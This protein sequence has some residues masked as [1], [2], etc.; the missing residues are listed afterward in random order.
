MKHGKNNSL[1][2][3]K[4]KRQLKHNRCSKTTHK[5]QKGQIQYGG[6]RRKYKPGR[7]PGFNEI[8]IVMRENYDTPPPELR[9]LLDIRHHVLL[10]KKGDTIPIT[11]PPNT[12]IE[13]TNHWFSFGRIEYDDETYLKL[14]SLNLQRIIID[15]LKWNPFLNFPHNYEKYEP[16]EA[17][18]QATRDRVEDQMVDGKPRYLPEF[19]S[20]G[21]WDSQT[22]W[23]NSKDNETIFPQEKARVL[24]AKERENEERKTAQRV[25]PALATPAAPAA[26]QNKDEIIKQLQI[27]VTRLQQEVA[28]LTAENNELQVNQVKSVEK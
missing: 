3:T 28:R 17:Y 11:L 9:K 22:W 20:H 24:I 18:L 16:H 4:H 25:E 13:L 10:Y 2:Q 26:E 14:A 6:G 23:K 15:D 8:V 12:L 5:R 1:K 27:E 19:F 21:W 7:L